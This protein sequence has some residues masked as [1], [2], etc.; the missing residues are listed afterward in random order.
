MR[1]SNLTLLLEKL[2]SD[3][4][5]A[6]APEWTIRCDRFRIDP[7]HF[8]FHDANEVIEPFGVDFDH[9]GIPDAIIAG[10]SLSV[11]GASI[12]ALMEQLSLTERSGLRI[13]RLGGQ[14]AVSGRDRH[15]RT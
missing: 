10:H 3:S 9:I 11:V 4:D 13:D 8:T 5:T 15:R 1:R 14:V 12:T 2:E 7:F 6:A